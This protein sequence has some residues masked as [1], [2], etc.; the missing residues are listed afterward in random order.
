MKKK[1]R[2]SEA[3]RNSHVY[4]TPRFPATIFTCIT[5]H[6]A[7]IVPA[8]LQ[9]PPAQRIQTVAKRCR[10]QVNIRQRRLAMPWKFSAAHHPNLC[11]AFGDQWHD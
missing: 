11:G 5:W 7:N 1:K 6:Y 2:N 3:S 9:Q 10:K 4:D 8:G